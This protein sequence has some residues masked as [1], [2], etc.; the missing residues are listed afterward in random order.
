MAS[1]LSSQSNNISTWPLSPVQASFPCPALRAPSP[2]HFPVTCLILWLSGPRYSMVRYC[3][4]ALA[5]SVLP[6]PL[7][8]LQE[9]EVEKLASE[10]RYLIQAHQSPAT[11]HQRGCADLQLKIYHPLL[12]NPIAQMGFHWGISDSFSPTPLN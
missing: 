1:P 4:M 2:A 12:E 10:Q 7:C 3:T 8:P 9:Q 11:T 6:D 5:A